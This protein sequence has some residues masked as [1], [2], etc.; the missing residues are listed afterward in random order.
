MGKRKVVENPRVKLLKVDRST[1]S[2]AGFLSVL[3]FIE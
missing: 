1:V 2:I 3:K